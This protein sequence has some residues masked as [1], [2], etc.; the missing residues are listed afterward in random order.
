MTVKRRGK[1]FQATVCHNGDRYRS[2][3]PTADEASKW[4]LK[5]KV[6]LNEGKDI[7]PTSPTGLSDTK[8]PYTLYDLAQYTK[9]TEWSECKSGKELYRNS[10]MVCDVLG[11]EMPVADI[12]KIHIDNMI[13]K[14][15]ESG[16]KN[17]TINRK[18]ASLS[19]I[20]T[21]ALELG[22]ITHRPVIKRLKEAKHRVRWY[23]TDELTHMKHICD[24]LSIPDTDAQEATHWKDFGDYILFMADTGL[25]Q[26]E[27]YSLKWS[28]IIKVRKTEED[29][30]PDLRGLVD[31]VLIEE[32]KNDVKRIVPLTLR[33]QE[34]INNKLTNADEHSM[35]VNGCP[36]SNYD[37]R[38]TGPWHWWT[39]AR[40]RHYWDTLRDAMG[41]S[42]DKQAVLHTLRHTFC[43]RLVQKGVPLPMVKELAGH[44]RLEMTLRYSHLSP[45]D[46]LNSI[47]SLN[48]PQGHNSN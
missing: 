35:K 7:K 10:E 9:R 20:F 45:H 4:A 29:G 34:I 44:K 28:E 33:S 26:G 3:F 27:A 12:T 23:T 38:G 43:S 14:W 25:R 17:G 18:L 36:L 39:K 5:T 42:G 22:V 16:T 8:V 48:E 47:E 1:K 13:Q 37:K 30:R 32:S 19:K 11:K 21:V 41:W 40:L 46:L 2:T 24:V 6:E 15:K 31:S